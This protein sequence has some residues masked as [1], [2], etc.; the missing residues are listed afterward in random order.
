MINYYR[1]LQISEQ[2][3]EDDIKKAYRK[4]AK[5]CHPD[6]YPGDR[7]KETRFKEISEAYG[8]LSDPLKRKKH[9]EELKNARGE[10]GDKRSGSRNRTSGADSVDFENMQKNFE[11]FFGFNP[12]T[13]KVVNEDKLNPRAK[14]P[15]DVTDMFEK[16]MGIKK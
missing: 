3:A 7:E 1:V 15:L 10:H 6:T 2:A 5:Q 12:D 16:F 8:V 4:L 13:K 14:N 11:R 9:D